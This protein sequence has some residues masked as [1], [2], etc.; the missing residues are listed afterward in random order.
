[1]VEPKKEEE[2]G[3]RYKGKLLKVERNCCCPARCHKVCWWWLLSP[4]PTKDKDGWLIILWYSDNIFITDKQGH[5][6]IFLTVK[7]PAYPN[8]QKMKS[9]K[10]KMKSEKQQMKSEKQKLKSEKKKM[11]YCWNGM[12]KVW[13][14]NHSKPNDSWMNWTCYT[15][16]GH[17]HKR[18]LTH[19]IRELSKTYLMRLKLQ[20]P[21]CISKMSFSHSL[22]HIHGLSV[23]W[24]PFLLNFSSSCVFVES[25]YW[26]S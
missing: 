8:K 1:M 14:I 13:N 3:A 22:Q 21:M 9:E 26:L 15:I 18:K 23:F 7:A 10:Q 5:L 6:N 20:L 16:C 24:L 12:L 19:S 2:A 17:V 11:G 4:S 25:D